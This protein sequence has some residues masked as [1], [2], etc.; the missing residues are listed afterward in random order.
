MIAFWSV[1]EKP[2]GKWRERWP[3]K[4]VGGRHQAL[5]ELL[6]LPP[7]MLTFFYFLQRVLVVLC[8][9]NVLF[10]YTIYYI[11][12]FLRWCIFVMLFLF[13]FFGSWE[14]MIKIFI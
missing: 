7:T 13:F 10:I 12:T 5:V 14:K 4:M 1:N 3:P 6:P 9:L 2:C 11:D 8:V